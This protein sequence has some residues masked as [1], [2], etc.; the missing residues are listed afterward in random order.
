MSC[1][2]VREAGADD[3]AAKFQGKQ[4]ALIRF[5]D[6]F[7]SLSEQF[8][9]RKL[10]EAREMN[11]DIIVFEINSPGGQIEAM[12]R[13]IDRVRNLDWARTVAYIPRQALSAAAIF[14]LACDEIVV[15]PTALF[16][17]AGPIFLDE[18]F[19]FRHAPEKVRSHLAQQV[20]ELAERNGR[21]PALAEAMVDMDLVVYKVQNKNDQRI[22]YMSESEIEASG[23]P[24]AWE[25]LNLVHESRKGHFLEVT[26]ARAVE[27][28]LADAKITDRSQLLQRYGA[29][30][31][32]VLE[33]TR[34]DQTVLILN[35]P[36][37]TGLLF[38]IGLIALYIEFASP[39]IGIGGLTAVVC[40]AL[41]FW[42]RFLGGTAEWLEVMLFMAGLV[43][44]G[45]EIFVLPG[46]GIW[47]LS[48]LI[49]MAASLI[50][51]SED[52]LWPSTSQ[53]W[54]S[55]TMWL[56]VLLG[57]VVVFF[58]AA[59]A[60][61][62]KIG[63]VPVLNR[64]TLKPPSLDDDSAG[65]SAAGAF[66]PELPVSIGDSGTAIS[67]LRPAGKAQF[68]EHYIDVVSDGTFVEKGTAVRVVK[69]EGNTIVVRE[70]K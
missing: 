16:G 58:V 4:I 1:Q 64:L 53:Q 29:G 52:F 32:V 18:G 14:S 8:V 23:D 44:L 50:L 45:V 41:F 68:G 55:M 35:H 63:S 54:S 25:K 28:G 49:L 38:V 11:A 60:L 3:R 26:G 56:S 66:R 51:A 9:Y 5:D 39:G 19:M 61:T 62:S 42:S 33:R 36:L 7:S 30:E 21:P 12:D 69:I 47:G 67:L 70:M 48:G 57:S 65:L 13:L 22:T 59:V 6:S 17:D 24:G 27:L 15:Q 20:R 10:D 31:M 34:L 40:F 43:L 46:F 37:V 2:T